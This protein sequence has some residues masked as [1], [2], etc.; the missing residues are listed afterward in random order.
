MCNFRARC[1]KGTRAFNE[2]MDRSRISIGKSRY[3]KWNCLSLLKRAMTKYVTWTRCRKISRRSVEISRA[4]TRTN[5]GKGNRKEK[6]GV[7]IERNRKS[8]NSGVLRKWKRETRRRQKAN[9]ECQYE[10]PGI[11]LLHVLRFRIVGHLF[12]SLRPSAFAVCTVA[13]TYT[14]RSENAGTNEA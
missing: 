2:R 13:D 9:I 3:G 7:K 5:E 6:R 14:G 8:R 1:T 11:K 4:I 12:A 10:L